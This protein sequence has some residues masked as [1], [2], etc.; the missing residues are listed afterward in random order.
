M[1]NMLMLI[2]VLIITISNACTS[3]KNCDSINVHAFT[4][5][6]INQGSLAASDTNFI[7]N[8]YDRPNGNV[9][10]NLPSDEEAGW[11]IVIE[12]VKHDFFKVINGWSQEHVQ[13]EGGA[14]ANIWKH[15]WMAE[16]EFVWI[17]K[18]TVGTNTQNYDGQVINLHKEPNQSSKTVAKIPYAQTVI[19]WDACERWAFVEG[20]NENRER[21]RGWLA[22]EDQC[23]NPYT[24]CN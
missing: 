1:K 22:P 3:S 19:I 5:F 21:I 6:Q 10:F 12:E 17:Q 23:A 13:K 18:G 8:V 2:P 15:D 14:W 11:G 20:R 9:I 7:F 16:Y 4:H 24:T